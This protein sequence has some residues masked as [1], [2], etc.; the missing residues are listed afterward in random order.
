[1]LV[2]RPPARWTLSPSPTPAPSGRSLTSKI[3]GRGP[4]GRALTSGLS[5]APL[6]AARSCARSPIARP[7]TPTWN[8]TRGT[9]GQPSRRLCSAP[10]G[11]SSF[12]PTRPQASSRR[13]PRATSPRLDTASEAPERPSRSSTATTPSLARPSSGRPFLGPTAQARSTF[14]TGSTSPTI[15]AA[16]PA[17]ATIRCL[18]PQRPMETGT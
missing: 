18:A 8:S 2:S 6:P 17:I 15:P 5:P 11:R 14:R 10:L 13:M 12:R 4:P 9:P 1:M 16:A 3:A 7:T